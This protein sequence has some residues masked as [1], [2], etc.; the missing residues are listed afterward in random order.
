MDPEQFKALIAA[1]LGTACSAGFLARWAVNRITKAIDDGSQAQKEAAE[2][3]ANAQLAAAEKAA[4]AQLEQAHAAREQ[5][6][7]FAGLATKIDD[8]T[9]FVHEHT[10][11]GDERP[12]IESERRRNRSGPVP[13]A[14]PDGGYHLRKGTR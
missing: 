1:L 6:V 9:K 3:A 2:R 4:D 12:S 13:R 10:P 8:V 5:A 11:V 7:A 14:V